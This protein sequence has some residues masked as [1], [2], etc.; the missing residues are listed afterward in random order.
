MKYL[1]AYAPLLQEQ[2]RV[3][4][5]SGGLPAHVQRK[6][7]DAHAARTDKALY[8]YVVALKS[9]YLRSADPLSKVVYDNKLQVVA[10]ALGTHTAVSTGARRQAQGQTRDP[11]CRA[12]PSPARI[13]PAHDHGA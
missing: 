3:L 7:P 8:D 11:H 6:Y 10:H 13:V 12:V 9:A 1:Q 4:I 5:D 2:A